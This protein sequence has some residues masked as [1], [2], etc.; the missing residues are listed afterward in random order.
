VAVEEK[1]QRQ[2]PEPKQQQL[3]P[4]QSLSYLKKSINLSWA[5]GK[6]GSMVFARIF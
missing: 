6:I 4:R 5:A 3:K 1:K 2:E